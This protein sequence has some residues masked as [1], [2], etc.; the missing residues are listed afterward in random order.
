MQ[1]VATPDV[2]AAIA[3]GL[4]DWRVLAQ[5]L[6]ARYRVEGEDPTVAASFVSAVA[7]VAVT[8]GRQVPEIRLT[9]GAVDLFLYTSDPAGERRITA[10]DLE[11]A[12]L[13]SG[14]A[15]KFRLR[16]VPAEVTQ[17]ELALDTV[18]FVT[19]GPFWAALLTGDASHTVR[20]SVFDPA[21]RVPAL[22]FQGT[23]PHDTPRQ[24]WHLDVWLAPEAVARRIAAAVAAGGTVVDTSG[25]PAYTVLADPDGNK[26]CVA[27]AT[28]RD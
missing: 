18:D 26:V 21:N 7:Q 23:G 4:G 22:W 12:R 8:A 13:V 19:A 15:A 3:G 11:L 2:L 6:A 1:P 20:D 5:P 9:D 28:G 17:V 10:Q 16:A 24:R 14:L 25:A 27:C